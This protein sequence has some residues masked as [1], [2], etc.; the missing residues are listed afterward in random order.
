MNRPTQYFEP[1]C[2]NSGHVFDADGPDLEAVEVRLNPGLVEGVLEQ[3]RQELDD[4]CPMS[5]N[6]FGCNLKFGVTS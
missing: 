2:D 4:L 5:Q 1:V 3:Q 6:F